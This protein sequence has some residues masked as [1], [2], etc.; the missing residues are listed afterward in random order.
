MD[1]SATARR[2]SVAVFWPIIGRL[3][4]FVLVAAMVLVAPVPALAAPRTHYV[5]IEASQFAFQPGRIRIHQGDTLVITLSASD[6]VHGFYLEGYGIS[7]R[8]E[9][10]VSQQIT[11]TADRRGKFRYRCSVSCGALHPF[12]IG[13]LIVGPNV[14]FWRAV[15]AAIAALS[16]LLVHFRYKQNST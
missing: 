13:E 16:G 6:V 8:V 10:G 1:L 12:M 11:I 4:P 15:G 7:Q 3:L 5:E 14:P 9:P 2:S